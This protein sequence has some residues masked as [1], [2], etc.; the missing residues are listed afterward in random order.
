MAHVQLEGRQR[1][2]VDVADT[3]EA[4]LLQHLPAAVAF[5]AAALGGGAVGSAAGA[6]GPGDSGNRVLIHCAQGVS[7]SAAVAVAYLMARSPGLEPE[8]ALA[9]LR[10]KYPAAAP[11]AGGWSP[12]ALRAELSHCLAQVPNASS[13]GIGSS[14]P[15]L[16]GLVHAPTMLPQYAQASCANWSCSLPWA[17]AWRRATC[18]TS[19]SCWSR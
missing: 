2:L 5:V 9:A 6:A 7:R 19:G 16:T 1:H 3:E 13:L 14:Q 11:N 18:H 8:A 12:A 10:Q 15:Q 4:N 17:A